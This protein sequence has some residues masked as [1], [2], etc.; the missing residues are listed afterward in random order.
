MCMFTDKLK[1]S[2]FWTDY[3]QS[4]IVRWLRRLISGKSDSPELGFTM[5]KQS[6]VE[7]VGETLCVV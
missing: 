4:D 7:R 6:M 2:N 3:E 1:A 5:Q